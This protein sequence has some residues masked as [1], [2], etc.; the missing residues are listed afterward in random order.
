MEDI[1]DDDDSP[2]EWGQWESWPAPAPEPAA[3]VLVMR[4]DGCVMPRRLTHDAE[5]LSSRAALPAPD[6]V[7]VRPEQERGHA[8]APPTHFDEA[9]A[10]PAPWQEFQDHDASLNNTPNEALRIHGG[11]LWRAFQVRVFV[12]FE[13]RSPVPFAFACF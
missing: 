9:Q 3:G 7:V 4:E 11:P 1:P 12:R 2:L 10:E 13:V 8:S 6:V 5:A